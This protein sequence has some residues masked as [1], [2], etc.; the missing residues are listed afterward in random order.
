MRF[1]ASIQ[2]SK[3]IQLEEKGD[4]PAAIAA[5]RWSIR[6]DRKWSVPRYNLGLLFKRQHNWLE[7]L[8]H[9][10]KAVELDPTD[11]AAW[12]NLGIAATALGRWNRARVAWRACGI[13]VPEGDGPIEMKLGPV[14]VRL[15]ASSNAEVVWCKRIDPAR[16]IIWNV[17]LPESG[18]RAGDLLLHDGAQTGT[19]VHGGI[20]VPVF[21]EL[22]LLQPSSLGTFVVTIKGLTGIEA[23]QLVQHAASRNVQAEDWSS[24][25]RYLCRACSEGAVEHSHQ[26]SSEETERR[27]GIAASSEGEVRQ[28]IDSVLAV[29][30]GATL[31]N[32]ECAIAP[33]PVQ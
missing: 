18:H 32:I 11:Q 15:N 28:V 30:P 16:A 12:W 25:V 31:E 24:Q 6:W 26:E 22:V 3:A 29:S 2:N 5:Y 21:D 7:S 4:I 27:I 9:N 17:P 13:D 1:L 14:P 23:E 33:L 10:E 19:R 8:Q 20:E